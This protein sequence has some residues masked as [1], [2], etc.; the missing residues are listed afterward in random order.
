MDMEITELRGLED[1]PGR[2]AREIGL[3]LGYRS[4]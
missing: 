3:V 2:Y 4:G 1:M